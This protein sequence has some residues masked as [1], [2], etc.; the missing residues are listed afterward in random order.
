M[1]PASHGEGSSFQGPI[2]SNS[3][4]VDP[5]IRTVWVDQMMIQTP[6]NRHVA[7]L[8]FMSKHI[9]MTYEVARLQMSEELVRK[10]IDAV[11]RHMNYYPERPA[12]GSEDLPSA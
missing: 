4:V 2:D 6:T 1:H 11:A 5:A 12:P 10:M 9:E 8:R 7:C 3:I